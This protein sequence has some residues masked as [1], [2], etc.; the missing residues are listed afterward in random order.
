MEK[1]ELLTKLQTEIGKPDA[2]GN[3]GVT[4]IS[5]RTLDTY[6]ESILP[7]LGENADDA[8]VSAHAAILKS[9]G[10]QI[11]HE[12]AEFVKSY[13]PQQPKQSQ[14]DSNGKEGKEGGGEESEILKMLKQISTDNEALKQRLDKREKEAEQTRIKTLVV[15]GLK[16]K[17]ATDE[18]VLKNCLKG[19]EFDVSKSVEEL[20]DEY[21]KVYDAE[22]KEARGGADAPRRGGSGASGDGFIDSFFDE[23][24][25]KGKF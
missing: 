3:Y 19:V 15:E 24:K 13:K 23:M 22:Y 2:E 16:S 18:Y 12:K 25:K 8:V 17:N 11:R 9:I 4:G 20:V 1:E 14:P 5:Q 6:I 21:I 10:G 7:T